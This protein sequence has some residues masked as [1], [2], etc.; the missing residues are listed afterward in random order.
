MSTF[1]GLSLSERYTV[2]SLF[3]RK[4]AQRV[5]LDDRNQ[6][7]STASYLRET[8][9]LQQ[10]DVHVLPVSTLEWSSTS[11]SFGSKKLALVD[12]EQAN[13]VSFLLAKSFLYERPIFAYTEFMIRASEFFYST[14]QLGASLLIAK[15]ANDKLREYSRSHKFFPN[16]TRPMAP[17]NAAFEALTS[18]MVLAFVTGHEVGHLTSNDSG[19]LEEIS[20]WVKSTYERNETEPG[21]FNEAQHVRFLKPESVQKFDANGFFAGDILL[22]I[23]FR[24]RWDHLKSLQV[25]EAFSDVLGLVALT[26]SAIDSNVEADT[27]ASTVLELLEFTEM[28]MSLKRLLPRLPI[29]GVATN[30]PYESTSLGFRRFM[31]VEAIK[32]MRKRMLPVPEV[33]SAYWDTISEIG[34]HD[35]NEKNQSGDLQSVSNRTVHIA[36][37]ALL[38]SSFGHMPEAPTEELIMEKYGPMAGN[39]FFLA[40]CQKIPEVWFRINRHH[41]WTPKLENETVPVGYASAICDLANVVK[42]RTNT[43]AAEAVVKRQ[44]NLDHSAILELIR[45]PRTQ[46]FHRRLIGR[47]PN[48]VMRNL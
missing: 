16:I 38:V 39:G 12:V 28:L 42:K 24:D 29:R 15:K 18:G 13:A 19:S 34:L 2:K 30:V 37:G 7:R 48:S 22:G 14:G 47:W 36:R 9:H 32:A 40:S 20:K 1:S 43:E 31:F 27:A 44:T 23:K 21:R 8:F 5:L 26:K 35:L 10:Q 4:V 45:H 46:I 25:G 11:L 33:V 3:R 17:N 41:D 6:V